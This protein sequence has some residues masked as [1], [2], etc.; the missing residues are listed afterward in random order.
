MIAALPR[1]DEYAGMPRDFLHGTKDDYDV[2][3]IGS[4]L[5]GLTAANTLGRAGY[6]VLLVVPNCN[7]CEI[8]VFHR[9]MKPNKLQ[10]PSKLRPK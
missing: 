7:A 6:S 9:K 8:Y 4:G 5:A 3:V 10:K 2:V 1:W